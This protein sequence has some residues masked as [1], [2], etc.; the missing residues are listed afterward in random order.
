MGSD[1]TF[2]RSS[3]GLTSRAATIHLKALVDSVCWFMTNMQTSKTSI[4]AYRLKTFLNAAFFDAQNAV[5]FDIEFIAGEIKEAP[6]FVNRRLMTLFDAGRVCHEEGWLFPEAALIEAHRN[7]FV[8]NNVPFRTT[9]NRFKLQSPYPLIGLSGKYAQLL[10]D[11]GERATLSQFCV[12]LALWEANCLKGQ[13]GMTAS[14]IG[15]RINLQKST[16]STCLK[17]MCEHGQLE[18]NPHS[19]DERK[20]VLKLNPSHPTYR[21]KYQTLK[22]GL[23]TSAKPLSGHNSAWP[24]A[25]EARIS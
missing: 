4:R 16:L 19:W 2:V 21:E 25:R 3:A 23:P 1:L 20:T 8:D 5:P 12:E 14:E 10:R 22:A 24:A 11:C 13:T 15:H 9:E 7:C 17:A 6:E 18:V